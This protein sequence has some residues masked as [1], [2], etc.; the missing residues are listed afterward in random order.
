LLSDDGDGTLGALLR[1]DLEAHLAECAGCRSLRAALREVVE[2]LKR[3]PELAAPAGLGDRVASAVARDRG[4]PARLRRVRRIQAVAA[5]GD[6]GANPSLF[7]LVK[8]GCG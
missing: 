4:A 5:D 3:P 2:A 6:F 1:A 7:K 8:H